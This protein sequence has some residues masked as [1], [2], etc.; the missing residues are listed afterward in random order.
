MQ[1]TKA[2]IAKFQM[3]YKER[4]SLELSDDEAKEKGL[5]LVEIIRQTYKPIQSKDQT[6]IK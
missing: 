1:L 6:G 3:L 2:Q 4:F 5:K